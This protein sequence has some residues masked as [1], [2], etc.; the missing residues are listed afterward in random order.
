M[1]RSTPPEDRLSRLLAAPTAL[2]EEA[3]NQL[4]GVNMVMDPLR[5]GVTGVD[6]T[7]KDESPSS[8][9]APKPLDNPLPLL[10]TD[11]AGATPSM[12]AYP[13]PRPVGGGGAGAGC[14]TGLDLATGEDAGEEAVRSGLAT[15]TVTLFLLL[16]TPPVNT[17]P[18]SGSKS[19]TGC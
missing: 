12:L 17:E 1:C 9:S 8:F 2:L 5:A 19:P 16:A 18:I 10:E 6:E 4:V 14:S 15:V 7:T 13:V 3:G 11:A